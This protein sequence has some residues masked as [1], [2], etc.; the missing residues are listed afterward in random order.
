MN[1]IKSGN[2][3]NNNTESEMINEASEHL[4]PWNQERT[5]KFTSKTKRKK[6]T[7]QIKKSDTENISKY[8]T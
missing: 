4:W 7:F 5:Q 1:P 8:Q 2:H 3:N 6:A